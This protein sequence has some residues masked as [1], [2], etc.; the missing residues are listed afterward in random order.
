MA[1]TPPPTFRPGLVELEPRTV[2]A[3]FGVPQLVNGILTVRCDNQPSI[4]L[5]SQQPSGVVRVLD[6]LNDRVFV[7][8]PGQVRRVDVFGG[9]GNDTLSARGRGPVLVR[10]VGGPGDDVLLGGPGRQILVGGPGNDFLSGGAGPDVLRGGPGNDVLFGGA[11]NDILDG[12]DGND[13]LNGGPGADVLIGGDGNDVLVAIDNTTGD[14]V[15]PGNGFDVVWVD[16]NGVV[17]DELTGVDGLDTIHTVAAFANGADR[18]LD[19]DLIDDPLIPGSVRYESYRGYPL[20]GP[21][22]PRPQDIAQGPAL[23]PSGPALDDGW[24][25]SAVGAVAN[26]NPDLIRSV[27]VDFGDGTFGV[28]LDGNYYRVDADLPSRPFG[29]FTPA[30]AAVDSNRGLWVAIFE[31][32]FA[33]YH[34]GLG[35]PAYSVLAGTGGASPAGN[36]AVVF[37]ALGY[38]PNNSNLSTFFNDQ[39]LGLFIKT[40]LDTGNPA[41]VVINSAA[42]GPLANNTA[43]TI[44]RYNLN[45][46]GDVQSVVLYHPLGFELTVS[47]SALYASGGVIEYGT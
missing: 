12:G 42:P 13:Y 36:P 14:R 40:L 15:D 35:T 5:V 28:W 18:T 47:I 16:R 27:M 44:L 21:L 25:L 9:A 17:T 3:I 26:A 29:S 19:G 39:Q 30:Y 31:K 34:A 38:T 22:G 33:Y 24:L 32:A 7:Y 23:G 37:A 20:F 6:V 8:G 11:G 46:V 1:N 45:A 2:P 43:Y 4:V 41:A 10:L